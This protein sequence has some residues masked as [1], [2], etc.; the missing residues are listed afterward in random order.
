MK[1]YL[2][3]LVILLQTGCN[4]S[5]KSSSQKQESNKEEGTMPVVPDERIENSS[6]SIENLFLNNIE[7]SHKK[8]TFLANKAIQFD[9]NLSFLGKQ[10]L[11]A[12]ISMLTNSTKIKIVKRDGS[13]LFFD[14][15]KVYLS[16]SNTD[17]KGA[18]FDMFTWTYFFGFPYKLNDSGTKWKMQGDKQLLD[19]RYTTAKLTFEEGTGDAPDDWYIAFSDPKTNLLTAAAYIV[20]FGSKDVSKAASDPHLIVY[21]NYKNIEGVPIARDWKFYG[22]KPE[23]GITDS[24][25]KGTLTNIK[26]INNNI[27]S[28]FSVPQNRKTIE[29]SQ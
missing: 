18:R 23:K 10:R 20:T 28:L 15:K 3:L 16:P 8:D 13:V 6:N 25:G 27:D 21:E 2:L 26:F 1:Y 14:G 12:T 24:L 9:L 17:E 29:L 5:S 19:N 22:W 4:N 7:K 11:D